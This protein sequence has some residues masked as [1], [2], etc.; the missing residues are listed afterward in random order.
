M[1]TVCFAKVLLSLLGRSNFKAFGLTK[2][3][4]NIKNINNKNTM[5]VIDDMLKLGETLFLVLIAISVLVRE[6]Y[7]K[8]QWTLPQEE[9]QFSLLWLPAY[10]NQ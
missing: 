7:L 10:Y 1:E 2:V 3:E 8:I 6:G 4:V 9:K 5:S